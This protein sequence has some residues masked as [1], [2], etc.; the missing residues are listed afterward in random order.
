VFIFWGQ[1]QNN[2]YKIKTL[3]LQKPIKVPFKNL[4]F[5]ENQKWIFNQKP[6]STKTNKKAT[7][8]LPYF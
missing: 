5:P 8:N 3:Y 7:C 4:L 6:Y 2:G 1:T